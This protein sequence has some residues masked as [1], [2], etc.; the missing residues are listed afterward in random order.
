MFAQCD[1]YFD[2]ARFPKMTTTNELFEF[3]FEE[4]RFLP[5]GSVL[6]YLVL[7][8]LQPRHILITT[9]Y[10][11]IELTYCE[12]LIPLYFLIL[13]QDE[14]SLLSQADNI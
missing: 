4:N 2:P 11:L 8:A 3:D 10:T 5:S 9:I 14:V 12:I 1:L 13:L 6:Y 7:Y